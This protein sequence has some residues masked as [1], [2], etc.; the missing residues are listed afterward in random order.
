[1]AG[2]FSLSALRVLF[3]GA[4]LAMAASAAFVGG[5]AHAA[6][7]ALGTIKT[8]LN[9]SGPQ[10]RAAVLIRTA[11]GLEGHWAQPLRWH[12]GAME[13]Q[14][15]AYSLLSAN[16]ESGVFAARSIE[17]AQRSIWRA[18][19]QAPA[20]TRLAVFA[21]NGKPNALCDAAACLQRSWRALPLAPLATACTRL[22]LGH[23]LGL[24]QG[25]DDARVVLM[26]QVPMGRETLSECVSFLSPID[27]FRLLMLQEEAYAEREHQAEETGR[28]PFT[29]PYN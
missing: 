9:D 26:T 7:Q 13:A 12:A 29:R 25:A 3:A 21:A 5:G 19:L 8:T 16:D 22:Q 15:W 11:A 1:M 17:P 18:P 4:A 2:T 23:E 28:S 24:V 6:A 14:S 10:Q 20:W 27:N